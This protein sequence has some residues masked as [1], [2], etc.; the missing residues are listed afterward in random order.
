MQKRETFLWQWQM[1]SWPQSLCPFP[2]FP[3]KSEDKWEFY[4]IFTE[5]AFNQIPTEPSPSDPLT[6]TP[7]PPPLTLPPFLPGRIFDQ[8]IQLA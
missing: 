1:I 7:P 8:I 5:S 2:S 3:I 4:V 6:P